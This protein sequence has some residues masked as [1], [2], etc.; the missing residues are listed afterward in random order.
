MCVK[1]LMRTIRRRVEAPA[2]VSSLQEPLFTKHMVIG[3]QNIVSCINDN[4]DY[5][6]GDVEIKKQENIYIYITDKQAA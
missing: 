5:S 2:L 4:H 6:E 3:F 1:R